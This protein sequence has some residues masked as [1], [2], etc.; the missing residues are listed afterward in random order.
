MSKIDTALEYIKSLNQ[1]EKEQVNL[2]LN[3]MINRTEYNK[4]Q[5]TRELRE[6]RFN[7]GKIC[8]NCNS[9]H[10]VKNGK[11]NDKQRYLCKDCR[12]TFNDFTSTPLS[13]SKKDLNI[14]GKFINCM[15]NEFSLRKCASICEIS[16]PTAFYW[17]HKV[18]DAIKKFVGR[19]DVEG[20][21]EADETFF[22]ESFKGNHKNS[23]FVMP[24]K[25]HKRGGGA[26]TSGISKEYVCVA[27][28]LD[29]NKNII[30]EMTNM[31]RI[32]I[33][34]LKR[35]Y[36]AHIEQGSIIC[37][38]SHRSYPKF[39]NQLNLTHVK[40]K[41]G[42]KKEDIYHLQNVNSLHSHLKRWIRKFNGVSTKHLSNYLGWYKY[43]Q[44][45][46]NEKEQIK[47]KNLLLHS[48]LFYSKTKINGIS[49]RL[50]NFV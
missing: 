41:G 29:R 46:K 32:S 40:L 44:F 43:I 7:K 30:L 13:D 38:D 17:R 10:V 34:D 27:T 26:K 24:R 19:G 47:M 37:T 1:S 23:E 28:A 18:L 49:N 11:F 42:K 39:A 8:P 35:L 45:F 2:I 22:L 15:I 25:A 31:G 14:W 50:P 12:K 48:N 4:E 21:I 6:M 5:F 36:D 9:N 16:L 20:I 3:S 33:K